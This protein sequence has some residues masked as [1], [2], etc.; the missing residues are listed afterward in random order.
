MYYSV[1]RYSRMT[2]QI[3]S[4]SEQSFLIFI[5]LERM[6]LS[7]IKRDYSRRFIA[8]PV[9]EYRKNLKVHHLSINDSFIEL[10]DRCFDS[11][12]SDLIYGLHVFNIL[13]Y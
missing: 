10:Y 7:V 8:L 9:E 4:M 5:F 13:A 1:L 2:A 6:Q 12:K 11:P 3:T